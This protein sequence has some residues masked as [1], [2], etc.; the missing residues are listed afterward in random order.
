MLVGLLLSLSIWLSA[1]PS[2]KRPQL[3]YQSEHSKTPV[4]QRIATSNPC[5]DA[6]APSHKLGRTQRTGPAVNL[7]GHKGDAVR[8]G[9]KN[10]VFDSSSAAELSKSEL[11]M[12]II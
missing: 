7:A 10:F 3:E 2:A 5:R 9:S 11:N 8:E 12:Y 1:G 4:K 6:D